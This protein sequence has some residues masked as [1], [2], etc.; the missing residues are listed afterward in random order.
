MRAVIILI[1]VVVAA[2]VH[3]IPQLD[4]DMETVLES[5]QRSRLSIATMVAALNKSD[6]SLARIQSRAHNLSIRH[7][8]LAAAPS[9][10]VMLESLSVLEK[11]RLTAI[12]DILRATGTYITAAGGMVV[13]SAFTT[14]AR[15]SLSNWHAHL[16]SLTNFSYSSSP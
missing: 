15:I 9:V 1:L 12:A 6:T 8:A 16:L 10:V 14:N 13:A 3:G 4:D 2:A 7:S 5:I 11:L